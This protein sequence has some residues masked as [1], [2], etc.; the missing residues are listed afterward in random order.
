VQFRPLPPR[1]VR[2]AAEGTAVPV[3]EEAAGVAEAGRKTVAVE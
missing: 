1:R 2:A 3:E